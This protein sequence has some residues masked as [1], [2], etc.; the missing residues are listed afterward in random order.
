[1]IVV[2]RCR[3]LWVEIVRHVCRYNPEY[4]PLLPPGRDRARYKGVG[5]K[6]DTIHVP[7]D[8]LAVAALKEVQVMGGLD[9]G[10]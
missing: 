7:C 4:V 9:L 1:M 2:R 3:P 10:T 5:Y 6:L 8:G